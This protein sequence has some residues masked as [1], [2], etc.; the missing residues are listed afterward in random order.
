[1]KWG[2]GRTNLLHAQKIPSNLYNLPQEEG[3]YSPV[4]TCGL[5]IVTV[6]YGKGIKKTDFIVKKPDKYLSQ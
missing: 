1:M 5:Y 4:L 6:Q 2:G 3:A